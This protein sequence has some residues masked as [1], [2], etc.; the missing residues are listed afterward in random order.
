[1]VDILVNLSMILT[2]LKLGIKY[3]GMIS[4]HILVFENLILNRNY[5]LPLYEIINPSNSFLLINL[6]VH[7]LILRIY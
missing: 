2:I 7:S 6:L 1:M 3:K 4:R 5:F